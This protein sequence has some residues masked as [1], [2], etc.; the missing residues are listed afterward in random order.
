MAD[1][2]NA[3]Q[4]QTVKPKYIMLTQPENQNPS[5]ETRRKPSKYTTMQE[6]FSV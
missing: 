2:A 1:I 4:L 3:N 5:A 6:Y